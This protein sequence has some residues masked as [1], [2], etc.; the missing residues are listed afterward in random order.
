MVLH[1]FAILASARGLCLARR[2]YSS[3]YNKYERNKAGKSARSQPSSQLQCNERVLS[4]FQGVGPGHPLIAPKEIFRIKKTYFKYI[5]GQNICWLD[6][7]L[8][9]FLTEIFVFVYQEFCIFLCPLKTSKKRRIAKLNQDIK[10]R[11]ACML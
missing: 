6:Q 11:G 4:N 2:L 1:A 9:T 8:I 5:C 3:C 7:A 10:R